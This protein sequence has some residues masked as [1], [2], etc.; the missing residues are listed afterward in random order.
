MNRRSFLKSIG[1]LALAIGLPA[2]VI[3]K[4]LP[5]LWTASP[6]RW[7]R[8]YDISINEWI[9]RADVWIGKKISEDTRR[10]TM[11]NPEQYG[12]DILSATE[13]LKDED[14]EMAVSVLMADVNRRLA[15]VNA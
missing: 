7:T 4:Q 2:N 14:K 9:F 13:N 15:K 5:P 3:A 11:E 10:I 12:V 1:G 6:I 8:D